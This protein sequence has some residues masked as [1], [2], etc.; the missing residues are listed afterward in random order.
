[1]DYQ[2]RLQKIADAFEE[3]VDKAQLYWP[4]RVPRMILKLDLR[5]SRAGSC[6]WYVSDKNKYTIRLNIEMILNGSF[7]IILKD[8]IPHEIA[9]AM[10]EKNRWDAG[11]GPNWQGVCIDLGGNGNRL[12]DEEVIYARGHTYEY[13]ATCGTK[14]RVSQTIHKRIQKGIRRIIKNTQ[15]MVTKDCAWVVIRRPA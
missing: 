4:G 12:H 3:C 15:G 11:H 8:V 2:T 13:T 7:D 14:L 9:H 10:C 5:G 6:Q 1:M